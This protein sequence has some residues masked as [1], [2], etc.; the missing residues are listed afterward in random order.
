M[1]MNAHTYNRKCGNKLYFKPTLR[2][3]THGGCYMCGYHLHYKLCS[4]HYIKRDDLDAV[5]LANLRKVTAFAKE[6]EA[7]FVKMVERKTKRSSEDMLRTNEKELA[8]VQNRLNEIDRIINRLYED[9][10]VGDLSE[11]IDE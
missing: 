6:H 7:E 5:V 8:E 9:K 10:V 3:K 11:E 4:S 2:L 1:T